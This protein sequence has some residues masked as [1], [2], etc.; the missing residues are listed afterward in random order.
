MKAVHMIVC[1]VEPN[2]YNGHFKKTTPYGIFNLEVR[3][4]L[5]DPRDQVSFMG[6]TYDGD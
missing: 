3:P 1:A 4:P 5:Y 6:Y 2:N